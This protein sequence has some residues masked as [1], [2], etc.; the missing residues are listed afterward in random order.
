MFYQCVLN[1]QFIKDEFPLECHIN[2]NIQT[3]IIE[4]TYVEVDGW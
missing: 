1:G 3:K 4:K 2:S